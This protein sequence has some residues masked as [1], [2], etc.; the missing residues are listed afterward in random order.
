LSVF[1]TV[2]SRGSVV[3]RN[4]YSIGS[5]FAAAAA[6]FTIDSSAKLACRCTGVRLLWIRMPALYGELT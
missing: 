3:C 2:I 5:T 6:S 4:R 1:R